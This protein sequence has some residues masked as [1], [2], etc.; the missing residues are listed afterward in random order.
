VQTL[1][2]KQMAKAQAAA[3]EEV[4]L[5]RQ[6]W[7][8]EFDKRRKLHN[9]VKYAGSGTECSVRSPTGAFQAMLSS[10]LWCC[11]LTKSEDSIYKDCGCRHD[12]STCGSCAKHN[13][14]AM[15]PQCLAMALTL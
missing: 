6:R 15:K 11:A 5:Y 14:L 12:G 2:E 10:L 3:A 1:A 13:T 8:D 9:Q 4:A 7:R